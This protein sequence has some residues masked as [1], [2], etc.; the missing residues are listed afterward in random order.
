MMQLVNLTLLLALL[1]GTATS[2]SATTNAVELCSLCGAE[3]MPQAKLSMVLLDRMVDEEDNQ[4]ETSKH[5]TCADFE[6][7]EISAGGTDESCANLQEKYA[8]ACCSPEFDEF[9]ELEPVDLKATAQDE[10]AYLRG[11]RDLAWKVSGG[12][13]FGSNAN[14]GHSNGYVRPSSSYQSKAASSNSLWCR[15]NRYVSNSFKFATPGGAC[16]CPVC[17]NG[18]AP[19]AA[20][21]GSFFVPGRGSYTGKTCSQMNAIGTCLSDLL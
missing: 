21:G 1:L 17:S 10:P 18:Q 4:K 6:F 2:S 7:F 9:P 3:A 12:Q 14:G 8:H 5:P 19:T 15:D 20:M 16:K 11:H 13:T